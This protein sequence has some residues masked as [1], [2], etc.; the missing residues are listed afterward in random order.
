M[1]DKATGV[2]EVSGARFHVID[3]LTKQRT[4]VTSH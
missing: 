3:I 4:A 1:P 2:V